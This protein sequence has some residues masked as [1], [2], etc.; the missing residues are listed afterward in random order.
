MQV[1]AEVESLGCNGARFVDGSEMAFD[2]VIFATGYRSS[3]P[4]WLKV[5]NSL[6][7]QTDVFHRRIS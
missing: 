3:V 4:S 7:K 6:A 2:A 1:V 5:G